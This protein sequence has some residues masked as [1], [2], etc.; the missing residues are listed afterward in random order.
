ML[1]F[2]D[3]HVESTQYLTTLQNTSRMA[4]TRFSVTIS[5][6]VLRPSGKMT[7][8]RVYLEDVDMD[9]VIL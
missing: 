4:S 2:M 1:S 5:R 8:I 7:S 3:G 6:A 9:I